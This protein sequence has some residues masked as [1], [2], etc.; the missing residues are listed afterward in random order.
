MRE[1]PLGITLVAAFNIIVGV[2]SI[3]G[4]LIGSTVGVFAFCFGVGGVFASGVWGLITGVLHLFFGGALWS[5]QNWGYLVVIVLA[6]AQIVMNVLSG[7]SGGNFGW[8]G[9]LWNLFII[10]YMRT[11]GVKRFFNVE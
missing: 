11:D 4:G 7:F 10:W 5:G 8:F 3:I 9:I 2:L 6:A 1:R